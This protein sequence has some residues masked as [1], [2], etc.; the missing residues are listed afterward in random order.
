MFFQAVGMG[1][2]EVDNSVGR[3]K[4]YKLSNNSIVNKLIAIGI[5]HN[6]M[7]SGMSGK[8]MPIEWQ[9]PENPGMPMEN[10]YYPAP[11]KISDVGAGNMIPVTIDVGEKK[12]GEGLI[13]ISLPAAKKLYISLK[14]ALN[15][16][17]VGH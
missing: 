6:L 14:E 11:G 4:S 17:N 9:E 13:F 15:N 8:D 10:R 2:L 1:L 7:I 12:N 16:A 3:F 5:E